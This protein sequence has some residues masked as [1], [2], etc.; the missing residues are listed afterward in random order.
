MMNSE[1][2]DE[3]LADFFSEY[4]IETFLIKVTAQT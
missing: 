4:K 3:V 2:G 1:T